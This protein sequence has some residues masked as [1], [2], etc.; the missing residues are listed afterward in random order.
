MLEATLWDSRLA[1]SAV[2]V[3]KSIITRA[4]KG[5][6]VAPKCYKFEH[7]FKTRGKASNSLEWGGAIAGL[8]KGRR[9]GLVGWGEDVGLAII[10]RCHGCS[11]KL[12][13]RCRW[14]AFTE[15]G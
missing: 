11:Q 4:S 15:K 14:Q 7:S 1:C 8:E 12:A 9:Q 10:I 6:G 5:D 3:P 13:L 2:T